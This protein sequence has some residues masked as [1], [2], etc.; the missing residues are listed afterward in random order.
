MTAR[1]KSPA[2]I[3]LARAK[4]VEQLNFHERTVAKGLCTAHGARLAQADMARLKAAIARA[5][6]ALGR[7]DIAAETLRQFNDRLSG[8]QDAGKLRRRLLDPASALRARRDEPAHEHEAAGGGRHF[9]H[10]AA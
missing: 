8:V 3:K 2:A 1:D 9:Q 7:T 4:L 10:P 6:R 5:D